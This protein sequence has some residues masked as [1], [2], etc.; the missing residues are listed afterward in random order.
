MCEIYIKELIDDINATSYI[1]LQPGETTDITHLTQLIII[2]RY[3]IV[4]KPVERFLP[5]EEVHD[6]TAN[7]LSEVL[8][9]VYNFLI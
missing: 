9:K 3:I 5:F 8:E 7:G 2:L 1:L 6:R 4:Y